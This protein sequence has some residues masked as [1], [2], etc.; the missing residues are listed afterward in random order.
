[1][2]IELGLAA[3][4][5]PAMHMRRDKVK[6]W[7]DR[8]LTLASERGNLISRAATKLTEKDLDAHWQRFRAN[9]DVLR[10]HLETYDPEALILVGGGGSETFKTDREASIAVFTGKEAYGYDSGTSYAGF[11]GEENYVRLKTDVNL[12]NHI[13][14]ELSRNEKLSVAGSE[15]FTPQ[16]MALLR[17]DFANPPRSIPQKRFARCRH[18]TSVRRQLQWPHANVR[19]HGL[20]TW[21]IAGKNL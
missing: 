12:S 6:P 10:R 13:L 21:S 14:A 4:H 15:V 9:Y 19:I 17:D 16:G 2:P 1:M 11:K 8:V 20:R 18:L 7:L 3:S 5:A